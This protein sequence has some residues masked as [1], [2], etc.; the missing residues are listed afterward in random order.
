M[1][2]TR[3]LLFALLLCVAPIGGVVTGSDAPS[4]PLQVD[5]DPDGSISVVSPDNTSEYLAPHSGSIDH[6]A[7]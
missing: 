2:G 5:E 7:R 4:G 6:T 3:I 1:D